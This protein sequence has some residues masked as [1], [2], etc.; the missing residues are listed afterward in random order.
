MPKTG[1]D[2][3]RPR[4]TAILSVENVREC[5]VIE[6]LNR[7]VVSAKI[8]GKQH[9]LHINNTGRLE[10]FLVRGRKAF[11]TMTQSTEKTDGRLFALEESGLGA[12]IDTRIQMAA[13]ERLVENGRIPWLKGCAIQKRNPRLGSSVL[14]YL[15]VCEKKAVLVEVKS[16]VLRVGTFASYPDCP[17]TR[18]QRHVQE[19]TEYSKKGGASILVFMAALPRIFAFKP[20]KKGDPLLYDY[21]R[22]AHEQR[23]HIKAIGLFFDPKDNRVH[24]F[25]PDLP[26]VLDDAS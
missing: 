20:Y 3:K 23:V 9:P 12:L 7:F 21:L 24:L 25:D 15:L 26:V 17:T 11:C 10:E 1:Q 18:G 19:L 14:D 8:A 6:R 5:Q 4:S 2:K 13:F 16:A 22:D